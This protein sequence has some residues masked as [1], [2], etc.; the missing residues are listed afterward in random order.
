MR[1]NYIMKQKN[2]TYIIGNHDYILFLFIQKLGWN[3]D[4]F[5]NDEI[6]WSF[7]FWQYD[8]GDTTL[9]EFLELSKY[10]RKEI[11]EFIENAM[12]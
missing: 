11:Y 3:L 7:K 4:N 10:E 12:A 1:I 6:K 8:G 2:V 5:E 9:A